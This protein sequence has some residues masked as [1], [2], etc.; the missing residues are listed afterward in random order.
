M[1]AKQAPPQVPPAEKI[2]TFYP[3]LVRAAEELNAASDQLGKPISIWEAILRKL[4]LG[5]SAWVEI[6]GN[7]EGYYWW[8]RSVGYTKLK[9]TWGIAVRKRNGTGS[10]DPNEV[11]EETWAFS[12]APRWMRIEAV[13]KL[14]DLLEALLKQAEDTTNKIK[15]SIA[16]ACEFADAL[17]KVAEDAGAA[18]EKGN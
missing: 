8:D 13:G 14:P 12:E 18:V 7:D 9:D 3:R 2:Q 17:S 16:R 4:N 1:P 10:G 15:T 5:I 6:S 11:E